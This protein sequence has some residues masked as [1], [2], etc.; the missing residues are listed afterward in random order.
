[1]LSENEISTLKDAIVFTMANLFPEHINDLSQIDASE[2][3][4]KAPQI[5]NVV[6][7]SRI[8]LASK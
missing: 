4:D 6:N 7:T 2:F 1:M 8:I 3:K 5:I